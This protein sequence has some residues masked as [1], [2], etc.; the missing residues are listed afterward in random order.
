MLRVPALIVGGGI[1]GLVCAYALRKAGVDAH[2]WEVSARAG[3]VIRSERRDGY[4]LE[5]G[6]QSFSSSAAVKTLCNE[7]AIESE[8]VEAPRQASRYVLV[9]GALQAVPLSPPALLAS[10]LLSAG[11]KARLARDMFGRSE[12]PEQDE[13]VTGFVRRKFSEEL[14]DRLVG[15]FVSGIFAGDP[16]KLSLRSAFPPMYEAEK[17][18]GSVIRGIMKQ[19]K[20]RKGSGQRPTLLSF[21]SG[22]ETLVRALAGTLGPALRLESE[23]KRVDAKGEGQGRIFEVRARRSGQDETICAEHLILATPT[24]VTGRL[25]RDIDGALESLL[26]A[27]EYAPVAIVSLGYRQSDVG[28]SL[29]GFGFLVPRSAGLHVLGTVWNSSL[30]P[31]RAPN[32]NVLLT[33][34][35]GGATNPQLVAQNAEKL[36]DLVHGEIRP[37]LA[38]RHAP[39]F[40]HVEKYE[41]ALPQ[42]NLGH[43]AK[44]ETIERLRQGV[45]NLWLIGNYL[46]GPS[47]GACVEQAQA[48]AAAVLARVRG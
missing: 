44:L 41:R 3:G 12:P 15:P 43:A 24:D 30:F 36:A 39:T 4:L 2:V 19:M 5:F 1:S 45:P 23:A 46:R 31:A 7:L 47:I 20:V 35:I 29:E 28:H 8:L 48:V 27:I 13:S 6:P 14:L 33:S 18:T 10:S 11:T 21:R 16:E 9:Q 42:Y 22:N 17:S 37:L 38:I 32:G 26:A 40:V 25:I 34:F